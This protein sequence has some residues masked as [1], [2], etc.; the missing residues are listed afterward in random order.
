MEM[1]TLISPRPGT[2]PSLNYEVVGFL[3]QFPVV[4]RIDVVEDLL[5]SGAPEPAGYKA[6]ARYKIDHG[7][8]FSESE[9]VPVGRNRVADHYDPDSFGHP[10]QYGSFNVEH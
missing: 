5:R 7:D 1:S 4:S 9:R 3:E 8:L 10:S 2:C 6:A